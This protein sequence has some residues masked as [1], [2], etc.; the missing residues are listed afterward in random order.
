MFKVKVKTV[1]SVLSAFNKTLDDLRDVF[2]AQS[3]PC[4]RKA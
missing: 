2:Q 4:G 3:K 1:D